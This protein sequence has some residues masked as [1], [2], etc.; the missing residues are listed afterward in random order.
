ML[1]EE[2][3]RQPVADKPSIITVPGEAQIHRTVRLPEGLL[4]VMTTRIA[5][6]ITETLIEAVHLRIPNGPGRMIL[7][8]PP[9]VMTVEEVAEALLARRARRR[10]VEAEVERGLNFKNQSYV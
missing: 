10:P 7:R 1:E 9:E 6:G 2:L 4:G 3:P 5:T 8:H